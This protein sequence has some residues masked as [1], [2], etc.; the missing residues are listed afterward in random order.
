MLYKRFET[1]HLTFGV[2]TIAKIVPSSILRLAGKFFN[3]DPSLGA[4]SNAVRYR[5]EFCRTFVATEM[6]NAP[7]INEMHVESNFF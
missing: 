6:R 7:I 3:I 1:N 2:L 4:V 5:D